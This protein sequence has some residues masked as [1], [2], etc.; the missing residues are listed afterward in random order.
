MSD[1]EIY[2]YPFFVRPLNSDE[3]GGY[4][5]EFTDLPGCI[6]DGDTVEEAIENGFRGYQK[7]CM[8]D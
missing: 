4:Y 3:G 1:S 2:D 5:I 8:L 7:R 6:S